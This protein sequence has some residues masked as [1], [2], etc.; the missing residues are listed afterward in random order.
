VAKKKVIGLVLHQD[1]S[2]TKKEEDK[3]L[4]KQCSTKGREQ[5][6]PNV[7]GEGRSSRDKMVLLSSAN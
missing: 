7:G 6:N 4:G 3:E 1:S 2:V 5:L